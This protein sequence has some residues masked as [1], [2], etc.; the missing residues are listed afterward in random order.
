[1]ALIGS[2]IIGLSDAATRQARRLRN[3]LLGDVL[4]VAGAVT[5]A[6]YL[7]IGRRLRAK[8]SLVPYIAVVYSIAAW[9]C[10]AW[11]AVARQ[12]FTGYSPATYGWLCCWRLARN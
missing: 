9:S 4:A 6:G 5:V 2:V 12:S 10:S 1:M 11:S 3:A 7:L 8:L